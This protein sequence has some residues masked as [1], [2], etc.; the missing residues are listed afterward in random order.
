MNRT[1]TRAQAA[2]VAITLAAPLLLA[3]CGHKGPLYLPDEG[4]QEQSKDKKEGGR[5]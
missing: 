4:K 3:A 2:L 1:I 5:Y